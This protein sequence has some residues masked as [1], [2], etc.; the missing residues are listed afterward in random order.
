M[1]FSTIEVAMMMMMMKVQER[2][3]VNAAMSTC[4]SLLCIGRL[5]AMDPASIVQIFQYILQTIVS[6][7]LKIELVQLES[8]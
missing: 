2:V 4:F 7:E 3:R 6:L 1:N 8:G 5:P